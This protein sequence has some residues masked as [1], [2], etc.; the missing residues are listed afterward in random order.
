MFPIGGTGLLTRPS[1]GPYYI[2]QR[3]RQMTKRTVF[4]HGRRAVLR[5]ALGVGLGVPLAHVAAAATEDPAKARPQAGDEFV[6]FSGDKKGQVV[7]M[8][9]LPIGGPPTLA[10]PKDPK[11]DIVRKGSRLNQVVLIRL[12]E[13]GLTEETRANAADGVV[14]YGATCSHQ[15]CP[16]SMWKADAGTLYCSCH[17]S[18]YDPKAAAKVV[19]GPAP[20]RL[21]ML[22]LTIEEGVLVATGPFTGPVGPQKR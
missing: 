17:G 14:A 8:A 21:A 12:Q 10:Y 19:A 11:A 20:R 1:H 13:D 2:I 3:G 4:A 16:V 15:G 22:P 6:Y 5:G 7:M 9:D 18:Q